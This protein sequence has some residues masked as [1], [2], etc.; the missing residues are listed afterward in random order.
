[1]YVRF[2]LQI[3]CSR[4]VNL[5]MKNVFRHTFPRVC[6]LR[7][8]RYIDWANINV[9]LLLNR[10]DPIQ[11]LIKFEIDQLARWANDQLLREQHGELQ[12]K[13]FNR[14]RQIQKQQNFDHNTI[15]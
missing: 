11:I 15:V 7:L 9:Q 13:K 1:M 8:S 4:R 6:N 5:F 12:R 10:L 2:K 14:V 3:A